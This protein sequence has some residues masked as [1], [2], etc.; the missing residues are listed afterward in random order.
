[1]SGP[2]AC[3]AL[4]PS[5]RRAE[6][7]AVDDESRPLV[8]RLTPRDYFPSLDVAAVT[9]RSAQMTAHHLQEEKVLSRDSLVSRLELRSDCE[10]RNLGK[11]CPV[12]Q[13]CWALSSAA[14][15]TRTALQSTGQ[16]FF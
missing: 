5:I 15:R 1:M 16:S 3:L 10:T 9:K 4:K 7:S 13:Q 8:S 14:H 2:A 6:A 11:Y 12:G